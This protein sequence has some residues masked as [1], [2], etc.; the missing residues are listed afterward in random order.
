MSTLPIIPEDKISSPLFSS[1]YSMLIRSAPANPQDIEDSLQAT[2]SKELVA[3][4]GIYQPT[5]FIW[6]SLFEYPKSKEASI[7]EHMNFLYRDYRPC[8]S[9]RVLE[10]PLPDFVDSSTYL[11][12]TD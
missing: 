4:R 2:L 9:Y 10:I 6:S 5:E 7:V 11:F 12:I 1:L 3:A 8:Y